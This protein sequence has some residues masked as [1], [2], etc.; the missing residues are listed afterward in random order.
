M[1]CLGPDRGARCAAHPHTNAQNHQREAERRPIGA[2]AWEAANGLTGELMPGR[3]QVPSLTK[4]IACATVAEELKPML[5]PH[6]E[7]E[8]LEFG[9]HLSPTKLRDR[10]QMR[11]DASTDASTI[12]LGYGFCSGGVAGLRAEHARLIIPRMDDC[13]GIF[14]GSRAEYL[15]QLSTQPGTYYLTKGW[16]ECGDTPLTEYEKMVAKYGEETALW[17]SQE[18]L[19]H[20][21]RIALIDTGQ[22]EVDGY[23][24]YSRRVA[25]LFNLRFEEIPGSLTLLRKLVTESWDDDF[26]VVEPGQELV[27]DMFLPLPR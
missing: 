6:M 1:C 21:T 13:I 10:L 11:I 9:L 5:P 17:L 8:V 22:Y 19:K 18:V 3:T 2:T 15:R 24:A 26:V 7:C 4:V 23:R 20:Y 12:I 27:Q 16:I 14:L 25:E